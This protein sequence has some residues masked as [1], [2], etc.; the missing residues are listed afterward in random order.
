M[1]TNQPKTSSPAARNR[2][3]IRRMA[4]GAIIAAL[5]VALTWASNLIG[6]ANGAVQVR[7]SEALCVLGFFTPAAVPGLFV[8]CL[9][10]NLTMAAPLWDIIGGSM[11]TLLGVLGGWALGV[12]ARQLLTNGHRL[13]GNLLK[14]LIPLPTVLANTV[15]IP[16]V[17]VYAYGMEGALPLFMLSVGLGEI[18]SAWF[19]GLVLLLALEKNPQALWVE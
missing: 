2:R 19:L 4:E 15:I 16:L 17:L 12:A 3:R 11:A 1:G 14:V 7:L 6:L 10:A 8:G 5:Y 18:V 13:G 9:L